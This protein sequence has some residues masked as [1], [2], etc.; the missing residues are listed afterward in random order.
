MRWIGPVTDGAEERR[1]RCCAMARLVAAIALLSP[2][3]VV[4]LQGLGATLAGFFQGYVNDY[5]GAFWIR[6]G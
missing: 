5:L 6:R 2:A 3:G 1:R 4:R